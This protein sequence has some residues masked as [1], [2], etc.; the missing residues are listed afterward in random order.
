M[1]REPLA[2]IG[3]S[4]ISGRV[5]GKAVPACIW[6]EHIKRGIGWTPTNVM[7][8]AFG[9]ILDTPVR[10][11]RR[12]AD[13]AGAGD[14]GEGRFRGRRR[15]GAFPAG[16][17]REHR[18]HALGLLPAQFSCPRGA[19]AE[20]CRRRAAPTRAFEQEFVYT[21]AIG[22]FHNG[23]SFDAFRRQGAFA[24]TLVHALAAGRHP[25]GIDPRGVC[26]GPVR[27]HLRARPRHQAADD[28]R[29]SS[30]SW[31]APPPGG[32]ASARP[33]RRSCGR[34]VWAAASTSI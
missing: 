24:G 8:T 4:D 11:P 10:R 32:S 12:H 34:R 22:E 9:P 30:A 3:I 18:R 17:Y 27:D 19:G 7:I 21:G 25:H 28:A 16:G 33:S 2:L 5:R 13:A 20:G 26:A 15:L 14:R 1:H 23:Y 29:S 31:R 6:R